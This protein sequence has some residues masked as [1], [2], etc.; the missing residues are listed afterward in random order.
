MEL[1]TKQ[2]LGLA[3]AIFTVGCLISISAAVALRLV[4]PNNS[5][6]AKTKSEY[7]AAADPETNVTYASPTSRT[8]GTGTQ[9]TVT[10]THAST[11]PPEPEKA[12]ISD[13]QISQRARR[14]AVMMPSGNAL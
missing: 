12:Q 8:Y 13:A 1:K 10:G 6:T 11:K 2:V 9:D 3:V 5:Q 14:V 4:K 7:P